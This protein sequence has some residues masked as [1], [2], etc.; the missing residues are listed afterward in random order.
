M[1]NWTLT[2]LFCRF[3]D[4]GDGPALAAVFDAT[5][6]ELL[7]VACHLVRDPAEAEDLVQATFLTAIKKARTYEEGAP[8][9]AWFYGILWR[10]AAKVRRAAARKVDPDRV[11]PAAEREP[12]EHLVLMEVPQVVSQALERL[13]RRYRDV[14][15]PMLHHGRQAEEI[16]R[17]LDRSP[18]TVRSQIHRGLDRLR[19]ALPTDFAS[20]SGFALLS[21]RGLP[22]LRAEILRSAGC[23]PTTVAASAGALNIALGGVLVS[24]TALV[25]MSVAGAALAVAWVAW[26][27]SPGGSGEDGSPAVTASGATALPTSDEPDSPIA[28]S[29]EGEP[30]VRSPV[31]SREDRGSSQTEPPFEDAVLYWL[32]RFNEAPDS[33][34]HGW[35]IAGE[36]AELSPDEALRIM[37]AVWP[38]LTVGVRGQ[39]LKPFVFDGGHEHALK[40]LDLAAMDPDSSV[41]NRAF[42]YLWDYAYQDFALDYEAYRRWAAIYRDLPVG[43]VLTSNARRFVSELLRIPPEDLADRIRTCPRLDLRAGGP[44]GVDLAAAFRNAGALRLVETCLD[45]PDA[46]VRSAALTWAKNVVADVAWLRTWV[47][48]TIVNPGE[49]DS[50]SFGAYCRALGRPECTWAREPLLDCLQRSARGQAPSVAPIASALAEMG[51]P[52]SIPGMIEVLLHDTSGELTYDV[53]YFGLSELTGVTWQESYDGDWWLEWWEGNSGRFPP[54]VSSIPIRQ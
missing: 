18:G 42:T 10:E 43:E 53:G 35:K 37:T 5:A 20:V 50:G 31:E 14:L 1:R 7:D 19:R 36:I 51:D 48:P 9:K 46:K 49:A 15:E 23:S 39:A 47:L 12:L 40:L 54:E 16:A 45:D 32:G 30:D 6:R 38:H 11:A 29:A 24:K 21:T 28:V 22:M 41:Q 52:A 17:A 33:W 27:S 4:H 3:R 13:P 2:R 34:R 26:V 44:A 25:G 8:L